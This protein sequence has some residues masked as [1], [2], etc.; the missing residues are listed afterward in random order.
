VVAV[1]LVI[2]LS[3]GDTGEGGG[4]AVSPET[5]EEEYVFGEG[6]DKIA[7]IP[8][9]GVISAADSNVAG[10]VPLTSPDGL[11]N[12]LRQ[13]AEDDAVA[14]VLLEIDS[15]GGGVT[16]SDQMHRLIQ[17]F[18][19][20]SDKPVVA[21]MGATAASGGYYIATAAD[22]IVAEP[23]TLTGSLGVI[24]QLPDLSE[25][26][27][28]VGFEQEVIKSG[29]FKDMGSSF[30]D[31]GPEEREIFRSILDESYD[32]FV[33]VIVDGRG[34]PE[35]RV[36]DL[37]DGRVYS[38]EQA[39]ELALVD[40]IGGLEQAAD[41]LRRRADFDEATAVRYTRSPGLSSLLRARLAP[42]EPAA[43]QAL[44]AAGVSL[45]G[46]PQYLYLP[47]S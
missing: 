24:L 41:A 29:E 6:P 2:A 5:F 22:E 25:A 12:A 20:S 21:S 32:R 7:V 35:E 9:E 14:G 13:A 31:L 15:P 45:E 46:E 10:T 38:G 28:K 26:A 18:Q 44:E 30:R 27:D 42:Q 47:G 17:D 39:E 43:L 34:L 23:T 3:A 36:R 33:Q 16:A 37:A 4:P 40:E 1:A 11:R 19:G 8:V